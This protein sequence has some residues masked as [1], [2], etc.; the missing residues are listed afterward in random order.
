MTSQPENQ[1]ATRPQIEIGYWVPTRYSVTIDAAEIA[2]ALRQHGL[3]PSAV[4][5]AGTADLRIASGDI[6]SG[7][8]HGDDDETELGLLVFAIAGN[9]EL[10][11]LPDGP[12]E[13]PDE[14]GAAE[15]FTITVI[16][17]VTAGRR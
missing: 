14:T 8:A 2:G 3:S 7:E 16:P 17:A 12:A 10:F 5:A 1:P 15:D 9:S 4:L 13:E 6:T 11:N